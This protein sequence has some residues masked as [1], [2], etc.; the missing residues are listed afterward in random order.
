MG[1]YSYDGTN[2]A[3]IPG[4]NDEPILAPVEA[5][6]TSAGEYEIGDQF[7]LSHVLY[8]ATAKIEVGDT[9]TVGTNIEE[10]PK[11]V[12]Q[13][14]TLTNN[15]GDL[16]DLETSDKT[17]VVNAINS[18]SN[19]IN[20]RYVL[21]MDSYGGYPDETLLNAIKDR[22]NIAA[23]DAI[24]QGGIGFTNVNGQGTFETLLTG[25]ISQFVDKDKVDGVIVLGGANDYG[26]NLQ[27]IRT[28]ISSF[29]TYTKAQFPNAEIMIGCLSRAYQDRANADTHKIAVNAYRS[30]FQY[31]ARYLNNTEFIMH[32]KVLYYDFVH[33][34]P[35]SAPRIADAV[36]QAVV[37]G[38]CDIEYNASHNFTAKSL[39]GIFDTM[40]VTTG[41]GIDQ[42]L[43]NGAGMFAV[44]GAITL[45]NAS[46][47]TLK[48]Q[49]ID[50]EE[51]MVDASILFIGNQSQPYRVAIPCIFR[52]SLNDTEV[53]V[54]R[55]L[56][57]V[58][59]IDKIHVKFLD[60]SNV[61]CDKVIIMTYT[62]TPVDVSYC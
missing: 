62:S 20:K 30:C 33:P 54:G 37:Y 29:C 34:A 4:T 19:G 12:P 59:A 14:Q 13:I 60:W 57:Y 26:G 32:W 16:A 31:G 47:V 36:Y 38:S 52:A 41:A 43:Y 22:L 7:I 6:T 2:L 58:Y 28:A 11:I 18:L 21:I 55:C 3:P 15:I 10:S 45:T 25:S 53:R 24:Y 48:S 49:D 1:V 56:L 23:A 9:L 40:A 46:A 39:S 61:S 8:K 5:S 44:T 17:S 51:T 35:S 50:L 27:N 42:H